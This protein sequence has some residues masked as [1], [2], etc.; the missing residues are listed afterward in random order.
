M[1]L[2][3]LPSYTAPE[4]KTDQSCPPP[5]DSRYR[6]PRQRRLL[7]N[8]ALLAAIIALL[9]GLRSLSDAI[10]RASASLITLDFKLV[11]DRCDR[12]RLFDNSET[13][14][15]WLGAPTERGVWTPEF[16][17]LE[18]KALHSNRHFGTPNDRVWHKWTDPNDDIRWV[19]I[20][21]AGDKVYY[22]AK[23]GLE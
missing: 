22:I 14:L 9:L 8:L 17:N 5:V 23:K 21:F 12:I 3:S 11:Q 1:S 19:A 20:L 2:S 6:K 7:T 10:E 13:V 4:S 18:A 15:Q 16:Q